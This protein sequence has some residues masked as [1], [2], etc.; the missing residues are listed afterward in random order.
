MKIL[1]KLNQKLSSEP[2]W[3]HEILICKFAKKYNVAIVAPVK[4]KL[5]PDRFLA[6]KD[7]IILIFI[8]IVIIKMPIT[9]L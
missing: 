7:E 6:F 2:T 3:T 8:K 1:T 4:D 9:Y 5:L